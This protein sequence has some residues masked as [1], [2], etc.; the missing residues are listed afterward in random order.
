MHFSFIKTL[1]KQVILLLFKEA[2]ASSSGS[3]LSLGAPHSPGHIQGSWVGAATGATP[4]ELQQAQQAWNLVLRL[5]EPQPKTFAHI[6]LTIGSSDS[7]K[8]HLNVLMVKR[9]RA[10]A[11]CKWVT[12]S[13]VL[14]GVKTQ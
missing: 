14:T 11:R 5:D 10:H 6:C 4:L 13:K 7:N 8:T 1:I 3:I 12:G 9:W 2:S